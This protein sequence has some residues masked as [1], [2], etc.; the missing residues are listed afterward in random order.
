[1]PRARRG[2]NASCT[3]GG[4]DVTSVI[5]PVGSLSA[6]ACSGQSGGTGFKEGQS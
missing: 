6:S 3:Q 2:D 5:G 4:P 1:M